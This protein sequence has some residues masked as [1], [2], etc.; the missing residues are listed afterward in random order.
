[1]GTVLSVAAL[2]AAAAGGYMN[3]KTQEEANKQLEKQFA[4]NAS[5]PSEVAT[6]QK[7]IDD[8]IKRQAAI[9]QTQY[10]SANKG[11]IA[12]GKDTLSK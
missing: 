1:M 7:K 8:T 3:Y 6:E 9:A 10:A 5:K 4:R 2:A 11:S 12:T